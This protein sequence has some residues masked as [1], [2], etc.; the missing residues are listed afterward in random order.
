MARWQRERRQRAVVTVV[1]SAVLLL[2]T[3][4]VAWAAADR[5]YAENLKPAAEVAGRAIP[6]REY[7]RE[8]RYQLL[9]FFVDN[10]IPPEFENDSRIAGEKAR[11]EQVALEVVLERAVV[12]RAAKQSGVAVSGGA[13]DDRYALEYGQ[14]RTRHLLISPDAAAEDQAAA[15][16][17]AKTKAQDLAAQLKASPNDDELWKKLVQ[18]HSSDTGSKETG[19][20][21]GFA[22]RGQFVKEYE[23]AIAGLKVGEV[24]DPVKS[25]FGYHVIQLR[26]LRGPEE[27]ELVKRLLGAGFSDA[28]IRERLRLDLLREEFT[29]IARESAVQS[30]GEQM[31]LAWIVVNTPEPSAAGFEAYAEGLKKF[32]EMTAELDKGTDFAEVA[33]KFSDDTDTAEKGG[34]LGWVAR[35]MLASL[36]HEEEVFKLQP[37]ERSRPFVGATQATVFNVLERATREV[38]EEQRTKIQDNAYSHWLARRKQEYNAR[39]LITDLAF[40][41]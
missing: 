25:S 41:Q 1:F 38:T 5:Y 16:A 13:M 34:E 8:L 3:G 39:K 15:D 7:Q 27:S 11:Y 40:F 14:Y 4:L 37:G 35:G 20:D 18:E 19:G 9:K 26:E 31:R 17:A 24:S 6:M 23:D 32:S 10:A 36:E 30:P 33:K 29:R 21:L 28:E 2:A 22:A 12:L